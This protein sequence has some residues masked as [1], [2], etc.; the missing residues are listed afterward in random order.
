MCWK[1]SG[2]PPP[3]GSKKLSSVEKEI[4]FKGGDVNFDLFNFEES[5]EETLLHGYQK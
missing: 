5:F 2:S 1:V 3:D 4:L